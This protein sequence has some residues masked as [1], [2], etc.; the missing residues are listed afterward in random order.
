MSGGMFPAEG[1]L[2]DRSRSY[3]L[4]REHFPSFVSS[5]RSHGYTVVG[6]TVRDGAIV[7]AEIE[8]IDD[9][10]IGRTDRQ[11]PGAYRLEHREDAALFGYNAGPRS[12][13]NYL[14]PAHER[15]WTA[16][17]TPDGFS[18]GSDSTA[19]PTYAFLGVRSCELAAIRIQDRVFDGKYRDPGYHARRENGLVIA[20]ECGQASAVCFCVSMGTGPGVRKDFDLALTELLSPPPHRFLVRIGSDRGAAVLEG[21]PL[22]PATSEDEVAGR[23]VVDRTAESMG[24]TL[25]TDDLHDMLLGRPNHP[26]WEAIARRCL[27]C[28]NCTMVCP[29]CFCSVTE[30]VPDL[31]GA[32]V[33]RWRRW[34][35]CFT[36][37]FSQ[38][39]RTSVRTSGA[40]RYR[41]WLTHKLASWQDQFETSGCVG[42][43]RCITWCPVGID[44][45]EEV[46]ALREGS[47]T[48][49]GG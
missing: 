11:G 2:L 47:P 3:R 40:S 30:E 26:R 7:Y 35:S 18:V 22:E 34:D 31:D 9:L 33:E 20:V 10:P 4:L 16:R 25:R 46:P 1:V 49:P 8:G 48:E 32:K 29:T 38:M 5:L 36:L 27:S 19:V 15:L 14:Y 21:V 12:W 45:T 41:Q 37:G 42:C 43:G 23:Q 44:L 28:T 13:K 6:P 39:G 24:R 17:R